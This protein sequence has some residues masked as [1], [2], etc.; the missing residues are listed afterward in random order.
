MAS[1]TSSVGT[2]SSPQALAAGELASW[3]QSQI[4]AGAL[5]ET[6]ARLR[7]MLDLDSRHASAWYGLAMALHAADQTPPALEAV[8]VHLRLRPEDAD[9]MML[10][11]RL[12][13]SASRSADARYEL[14]RALSLQP[15][16]LDLYLSAAQLCVESNENA[17]A[18]DI[19][20]RC[21]AQI[22]DAVEPLLGLAE[23]L[24]DLGD[25]DGAVQTYRRAL[26]MNPNRG[27]TIGALLE[28]L[29][30]KA[31]EELIAK[32]W[33][34]LTSS[35]AT[36]V[37]KALIGYGLGKAH[38]ARKEFDRAFLAWRLANEA[39]RREVGP[40]DRPKFSRR[41]DRLI[42]LFQP[43][44][45]AERQ[46]WGTDDVRPVFIVGMPR[47]GTTMLEQIISAHPYCEGLGELPDIA[48][49][50]TALQRRAGDVSSWPGS[51]RLL[52]REILDDVA[53]R[54]VS[55]LTRRAGPGKLRIVDKAP[56]NFLHLGLIALL[57]PRAR[58]IWCQRDA[59]D[60][61]LSIYSE[62]F[63]LQ[64]RHAT[65]LRDLAY[66]FAEQVRL[67]EH[68]KRVLPVSITEVHYEDIVH[69]PREQAERVI[70]ALGL[71]W[72]ERCLAFHDQQRSVRTPSR[73]QVR[74]PIYS[75][76]AGRWRRYETHLT[77]LLDE[78]KACGIDRWV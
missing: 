59:R 39:R 26:A 29:G 20:R 1:N 12:L 68:W 71:E 7:Q 42:Q 66:Y 69:A 62:N 23:V 46:G 21:A 64:Q 30:A 60:V 17:A 77:P 33:Q 36:D 63:A 31:D 14:E 32:A 44:F 48:Q 72:D 61:C 5:T 78:L 73:W 13:F 70:A 67:M 19:Y 57:F 76:S 52:G 6:L 35:R 54:H 27:Y 75:S 74:Q 55:A 37:A 45:F 25:W 58:I 4:R 56:L 65:D 22:P 10:R 41:I 28:L 38:Q 34:A 24:E 11:A 16:R 47:T 8:D 40:F 9:A 50:A 51:L 49:L 43:E 53:E 15:R 3:V 18:E 2:G